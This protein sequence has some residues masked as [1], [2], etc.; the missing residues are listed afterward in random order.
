MTLASLWAAILKSLSICVRQK[1][2]EHVKGL[3]WLANFTIN[4]SQFVVRTFLVIHLFASTESNQHRGRPSA[5][6]Y[7]SRKISVCTDSQRRGVG[8]ISHLTNIKAIKLFRNQDL[9]F[10]FFWGRAVNFRIFRKSHGWL[11]LWYTLK[12]DVNRLCILNT[13]IVEELWA[14]MNRS[15]KY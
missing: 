4:C 13:F 9:D 12:F 10:H 11:H 15:G 5:L 6:A 2:F 3:T 1:L 8:D 14:K 7:L